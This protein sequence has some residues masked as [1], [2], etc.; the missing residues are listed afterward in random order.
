MAEAQPL[1]AMVTTNLIWESGDQGP[2]IYLG[3][4]GQSLLIWRLSGSPCHKPF[5]LLYFILKRF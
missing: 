2:V 5:G 3:T 4:G 1:Q